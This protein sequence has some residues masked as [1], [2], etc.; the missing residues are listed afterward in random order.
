MC[1]RRAGHGGPVTMRDLLL[2]VSALAL[3]ALGSTTTSLLLVA[4]SAC[5]IMDPDFFSQNRLERYVATATRF[6]NISHPY[7]LLNYEGN[8]NTEN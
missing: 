2:A 7:R 3:V 5:R 4:Q 6:S 8:C 1:T